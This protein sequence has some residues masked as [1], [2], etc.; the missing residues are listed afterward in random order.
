MNN[1][2]L[3][4]FSL[5]SFKL[6]IAVCAIGFIVTGIPGIYQNNPWWVIAFGG[7]FGYP[8]LGLVGITLLSYLAH[9]FYR[10]PIP[11]VLRIIGISICIFIVILPFL[12]L[13]VQYIGQK[14]INAE[15]A[16]R[17][18]QENTPDKLQA[19]Q[20]R[21]LEENLR[22]NCALYENNIKTWKEGEPKPLKPNQCP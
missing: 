18:A 1:P 14:R 22:A 15:N 20:D 4:R 3:K 11:R 5:F 8:A 12:L 13:S 9:F 21:L 19:E 10:K 2:P 16:K 7:L 6:T 17:W